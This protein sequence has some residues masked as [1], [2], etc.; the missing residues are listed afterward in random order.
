MNVPANK[1]FRDAPLVQSHVLGRQ[2]SL[3]IAVSRRLYLART[4]RYF[5]SV[6]SVYLRREVGIF[7][8]SVRKTLIIVWI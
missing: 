4:K 8:F 2:R 7:V 1:G 6:Y 5:H 3:V